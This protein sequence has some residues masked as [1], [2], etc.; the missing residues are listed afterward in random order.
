M[1]LLV[2][3]R[4]SGWM[5]AHVR[6]FAEG[7]RAEGH[8]VALL[9]YRRC[10][11][12]RIP[13]QARFEDPAKKLIRNTR[14]LVREIRA[15]R[16]EAVIVAPAH[17]TFDFEALR[18]DF[19]GPVVFVDMDGPNLPCFDAGT[20]WVAHVDL[21]ATV[22]RP[23]ERTL[24]RE[25]FDHVRY[26]PHGVDTDVYRPT[27]LR[28]EERARFVAAV[29]CVGAATERRAAYLAGLTGVEG[30]VALWGRDWARPPFRDDPRLAHCEKKGRDVLGEE[31]LCVYSASSVMASVQREALSDPPTILNLQCF[32]VPASGGCLLTEWVEEIEE[33]FE[34][35]EELL[36]FRG[37]EDFAELAQRHSGR[38]EETR[39]IGE[40]GRA[41]CLAE[42][43]HRHRA[44]TLTGWLDL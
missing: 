34:P 43:T 15:A 29:A 38:P 1:K 14:N 33:A 26:L 22:S 2:V 3:G 40:K 30:T 8:E 17:P 16:A 28:D 41:R 31:L 39:R 27:P 23:M 42:H 35:G 24:R 5:G 10:R 44:R 25:G 4:L 37:P 19:R 20:D 6:Q 12:R 7:F 21:L 18:A 32:A 9:D 11:K 13:G 36:V